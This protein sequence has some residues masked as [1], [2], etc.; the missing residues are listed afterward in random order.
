MAEIADTLQELKG[1]TV[2]Q[3]EARRALIA[4]YMDFFTSPSGKVV[5]N[6][7]EYKFNRRISH[8]PNDPFTGA[9]MEGQRS[10]Y[11]GV[12]LVV[13]EGQKRLVEEDG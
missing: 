9:Y 2:L 11:Q 8:V 6:D 5:L 1:A 13:E 7:W 10:M 3:R 12:L 4:A